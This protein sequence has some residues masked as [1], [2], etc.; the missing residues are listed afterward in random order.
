MDKTQIVNFVIE[1]VRKLVGT[2]PTEQKFDVDEKTIL[3]GNGSNI[4]SLSLVSIIV[5]L[6]TSLSEEYGIDISL[7]D[8]RA[9]MREKSPF[10]NVIALSDFIYEII[11]EK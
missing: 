3:F 4:D 7:T 8:D 2:L 6:E 10:D 1:N 9:M 5:D 11:S